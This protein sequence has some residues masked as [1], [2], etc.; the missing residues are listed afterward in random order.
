MN[1]E[2]QNT[3]IEG[4]NTIEEGV[5]QTR[6]LSG[7][8]VY[9]NDIDKR[10]AEYMSDYYGHPIISSDRNFDFRNVGTVYGVGGNIGMYTSYLKPQ[11]FIT[12][13]DRYETCKNKLR[14]IGKL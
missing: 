6:Y 10:A 4:N 14:F 1:T 3:I 8:I 7:I 2:N 13:K 5:I 9:S 11:N 12:G